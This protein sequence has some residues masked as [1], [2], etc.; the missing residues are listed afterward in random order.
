MIKP[1]MQNISDLT[2]LVKPKQSIPHKTIFVTIIKYFNDTFQIDLTLASFKNESYSRKLQKNT[3]K[4]SQH[5]YTLKEFEKS[6]KI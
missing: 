4:C 2:L 6:P 5:S 1:C 3:V